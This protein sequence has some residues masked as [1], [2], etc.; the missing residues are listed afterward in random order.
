MVITGEVI[1]EAPFKVAVE[2]SE[3]LLELMTALRIELYL[4][5]NLSTWLT[6]F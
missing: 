5:I 1:S 3:Y 2:L 4:E 6:F